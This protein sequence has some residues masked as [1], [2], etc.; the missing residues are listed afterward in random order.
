MS[1]KG[2]KKSR[3]RSFEEVARERRDFMD[4]V[5]DSS[6]T[7]FLIPKSFRYRIFNNITREWWEGDAKSSPEACK[8]AGWD[9]KNCWVREQSLKGSGGWKKPSDCPE[10]GEMKRRFGEDG[11]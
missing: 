10:L 6:I 2:Y 8:K 4:P 3:N 11:R 1:R 9:V 5:D 7:D